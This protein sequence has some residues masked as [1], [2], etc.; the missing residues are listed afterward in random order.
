ME[1]VFQTPLATLYQGDALTVLR[2]LP[3]ARDVLVV[4]L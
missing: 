4:R 3:D 1:S 2:E